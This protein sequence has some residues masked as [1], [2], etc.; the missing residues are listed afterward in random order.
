MTRWTDY[1][2]YSAHPDYALPISD[3]GHDH[4]AHVRAAADSRPGGPAARHSGADGILRG[5]RSGS[6]LLLVPRGRVLHA[7]LKGF[8]DSGGHDRRIR[9]AHLR[10]RYPSLAVVRRP[11]G[12]LR[13]RVRAFGRGVGHLDGAASRLRSVDAA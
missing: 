11:I 12:L 8:S 5:A 13:R 6:D 2:L 10:R 3:R 9:P 7:L 1:A 4:R